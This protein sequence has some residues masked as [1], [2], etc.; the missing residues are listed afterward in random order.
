[1]NEL[2]LSIGSLIVGALVSHYYYRRSVKKSSL[3]PYIQFSSAPLRGIDSTVRKALSVK[4]QDQEI[5]N[6]YEIQFLIANT[7]DTTISNIA[8]PL[9]L[10]LPDGCR[11]LDAHILHVSPD[12]RK[13]TLNFNNDKNVIEYN[14]AL[15]NSDDFFI[16]K[17]L[18]NGTPKTEDFA[19]SIAAEELPPVL[20]TAYL[21]HDLIGHSEEKR[22]FEIELLVM[23]LAFSLLGLS[24]FKVVI[25]N[26]SPLFSGK[27]NLINFI[28]NLGFS[29]FALFLTSIAG[30]FFTLLGILL[31][32]G[33]FTNFSF[34]KQKRKFIVPNDKK[35]LRYGRFPFDYLESHKRIG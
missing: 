4:Y 5:E 6:L 10:T 29:E 13:V 27:F 2:W 8:E 3:T 26:I 12:G 34:P 20:K 7:G 19:F 18:I 16:T 9:S 11:L 15:L 33:S 32:I 17:L 35:Y 23:G 24:I 1:M 22:E 25:D 30:L 28:S 14:F 31:S 21:S